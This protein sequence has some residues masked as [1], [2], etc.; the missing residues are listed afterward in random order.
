MSSLTFINGTTI[1]WGSGDD[2]GGSTQYLD[3]IAAIG[4]DKKYNRCLEWCAGLSAISFSLL[5]RNIV[6]NCVLMD[7]YGPALERAMQ[8]ASENNLQQM[9][10]SYCCDEVNKLPKELKFDLV[11]GNPPHTPGGKNIIFGE[12]STPEE[13]NDILRITVD[14]NW[15]I[16]KKFFMQI[17]PY[18]NNGADLFISEISEFQEILNFAKDAKL[19]HIGSYPAPILSADNNPNAVI[20]HFKY[21]EKIY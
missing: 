21:E 6:K 20:I 1:H 18:L 9:I 12:G 3:F 4:E 2:G 7:I 17:T 5:D 15:N 14:T 10:S 13:I 8:N 11:V 16:H 19:S